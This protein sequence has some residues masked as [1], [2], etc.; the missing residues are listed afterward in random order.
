MTIFGFRS[1]IPSTKTVALCVSVLAIAAATTAGYGFAARTA[2]PASH[3]AKAE[4][5][6]NAPAAKATG[7]LLHAHRVS[8]RIQGTSS[9]DTVSPVGFS[10]QSNHGPVTVTHPREQQMQRRKP[11]DGD[12]RDLPQKPPRKRERP[13]REPPP[14]VP[15]PF[16]GATTGAAASDTGVVPGPTS[17]TAASTSATLPAGQDVP[18]PSPVA[19][20]EG[21]DYANWG[22][23]HPPDTNGDVGPTYYIETVNTSIGIYRKSDGTR[24][25]AFTFD[26]FMSQGHFGNLCDTDNFGDPVVLYDSFEDRWVIT[27]FA[28]QLDGS[29][30]V[31]NPPGSFQCFAVSKSGDPVGGG[32]NFYSINTTGGLGDYP[33]FGIWPDGL[34]MSA[35][36]FDYA[37]SG[38][39]QNVRLYAFNKAQ[40][41]AGAAN[42]QVL[43]FDAPSTEF[44]LLPANARL[45]SGTPPLG[46]PNYFATVWNYLNVV[47][48]WKF[49]VNWNS[50]STSSLT[51]PFN[52]TTPT[53]WAQYS[54]ANGDA[55]SPANSLDTLYP[56]LMM[57]NQYTNIGGV[58]SLWDSHTAGAGNPTSSVNS[59]Q[60]A[61]RYYQLTV[62]GGNVASTATQSYTYSPDTTLYRFMPSA[63]VNSV[64]DM[65]IG[66][67]GS[68]SS[69]NPVI[70]YGGRLSGDP[71]NSITQTEATLVAGTGTQSGSC[72]STC[73]RWG[74]YSAMTL[75]PDGCTFWYA[76]EYYQV[77]GL[78]DNTRIGAFRFPTCT[79]STIA[80]GTIQGTVTSSSLPVSGATIMLGSGRST[81]TD[82]NG[83]YS[84]SSVPAGAYPSMTVTY[85][86]LVTGSVANITVTNGGTTIQDFALN[87]ASV[88]GCLTDTSQADFQLGVPSNCDLVTSPGNVNL[89][90]PAALNLSVD[91][92]NTS[93][94]G[95]TST[96][97]PGQ[98]FTPTV[99]GKLS[100][101]DVDV[102][103]SNCSGTNP[104]LIAEIRTT[105]SGVPNMTAGGL[106]A[107]ST[108]AGTS[109]GSGGFL[110]FP[111][112]TPP[113][114]TSGTQYAFIVKLAAD[115][116]TGTQAYLVTK[117]SVYSGGARYNCTTSSC[118]TPVGQN[119]NSDLH[120]HSYMQTGYA[121]S[122]TFVSSLKDSNPAP[123]VSTT[124]TTM[125][126]TATVPVNTTLRFQVAASSNSAG[127]FNFVGPDG[128]SATYFSNGASLAQ[129]DGNRYLKYEA[130]FTSSNSTQTPTLNDVTVCFNN[131]PPPTSMVVSSA[132]GPY[133]GTANLSATLISGGN[134]VSGKTVNFTLN[135]NAAG[136][137]VT[138]V[139][140]V[141]T[142]SS[143]SL[144]G[145]AAGT[146]PTGIGASFA[147]DSSYATSSGT[148]ALTVLSSAPTADSVTPNS[149]SGL[150][151]TLS[152]QYSD[153]NG[154]S[155][156]R[157]VYLLVNTSLDA[158]NACYVVYSVA[159]NSL[160]LANDAGSGLLGSVTPGGSGTV[161]NTRCTVSA[162][163]SSVSTSDTHL[164]LN[165]ALTFQSTFAGTM[166]L[167]LY[168]TDS[169]GQGSGWQQRGTWTPSTN[170]PPTA[171]SVTPSSGSGS[172]QTFAMQYSDPNGASDLRWVYLLVNFNL[173]ANNACYVVYSVTDNTLSLANDAGTGIIASVT[174]GG[175]GTVQN[176]R[177]TISAAGSSVSTSGTHLTVNVALTF[178]SL[179]SGNM[180]LYLFASD[181]TGQGSG[182]QKL[183]SWTPTSN[184]PPSAVSV[185]PSSGNGS[186]Q[187]FT[188][189]YSDANGVSDLRWAYLLVN[190]SLNANN[191]CYVVYS[192]TDNTLS[193]AND[194]GTGILN[195]VTPGGSGTVQNSR[196]TLSAAGSSVSTSGNQLTVN[197]ALTFD[198]S[199]TG[200]MGVYLYVS[201]STGQ[202]SGWQQRGTWTLP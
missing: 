124:W 103:C 156:L 72:G 193:L 169:T 119:A 137:A 202:G 13:E 120:F 100:R 31:I 3:S 163:G 180:G 28:F 144:S 35:N 185:T 147:G 88:S 55:P 173:D 172:T 70:R 146:Y 190:T 92:T 167:Y 23:G 129:F 165:V 61:V 111:F 73:T 17:V 138:N 58:E 16:S 95:F 153:P 81:T 41:Y 18:A 116:S 194:A 32:W 184:S 152:M 188:M 105:T 201:D 117:G 14:V 114:L 94:F 33:K 168:A 142:I 76:Q 84:F 107:S 36:M 118:S 67:S 196:C 47:G 64:G 56:R 25:A 106:L 199:F 85:P 198:P 131:G 158:N 186:P 71:L 189:V 65:A 177:C 21:L 7:P 121:S 101:L 8:R 49:Q 43:S 200:S 151:Q 48:V 54:G 11:F 12:L 90:S 160:S 195:S 150:S 162:S 102:F 20:F 40:M 181:S 143:A 57:Q 148:G 6:A 59:A 77:T 164:T 112:S 53:W 122:G 130:I 89:A 24:V 19:S 197:V 183:G 29:G 182:W 174:P 5:T 179:F 170:S 75:D 135:G 123:G 62:T 79:N 82:A 26:A 9:F 83:N 97:F 161:Q 136:S 166:G 37:A 127:P 159:G 80:I 126:W 110:Q 104:N 155:N 38:S 125:S 44:T 176:T 132:S 4:K 1:G 66:Y 192:N 34:Y 154:A 27:D 99:T 2:T 68:N 60:A 171:D 145:I 108:I 42:I 141:A 133:G 139:S 51:G 10:G 175:S 30:N 69:T 113:S 157:W 128:S 134:G 46:S 52:V 140:G 191:A 74:D 98:I 45:Q 93:G 178:Q 39:F 109:S 86:G 22:A 87:A 63:A 78:N 50:I 91:D 149:G 115:R 96:S 15:V 187:T